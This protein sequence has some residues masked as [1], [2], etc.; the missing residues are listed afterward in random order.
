ME[1]E[2]ESF[3]VRDLKGCAWRVS[4]AMRARGRKFWG[5]EAVKKEKNCRVGLRFDEGR[6]RNTKGSEGGERTTQ[7][8]GVEGD[9]NYSK[10]ANIKMRAYVE[11]SGTAVVGFGREKWKKLRSGDCGGGKTRLYLRK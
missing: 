9:R 8:G 11:N 5:R 2:R 7:A 1:C 10:K 3:L 4:G 6:G